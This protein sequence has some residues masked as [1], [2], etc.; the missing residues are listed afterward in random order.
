VSDVLM[1]D[2]LSFMCVVC[3]CVSKAD[4]QESGSK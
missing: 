2:P 4:Q 3:V 1:G